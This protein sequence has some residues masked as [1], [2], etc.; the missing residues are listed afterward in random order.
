MIVTAQNSKGEIHLSMP[1]YFFVLFHSCAFCAVCAFGSILFVK[2]IPS[3]SVSSIFVGA[4]CS[5]EECNAKC[6]QGE[7]FTTGNVL[8]GNLPLKKKTF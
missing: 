6:K 5:G 7:N 3:E 8:V 4:H 2:A 1:L